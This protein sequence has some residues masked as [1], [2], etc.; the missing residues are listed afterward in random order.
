MARRREVQYK[1]ERLFFVMTSGLRMR[2]LGAVHRKMLLT[3]CLGD[4]VG[5]REEWPVF[6]QDKPST[7]LAGLAI[8]ALA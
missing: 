7:D 6:A 1:S 3:L 8:V 5:K 4:V 2:C